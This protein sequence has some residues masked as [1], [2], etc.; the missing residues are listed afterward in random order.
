MIH[1]TRDDISHLFLQFRPPKVDYCERHMCHICPTK[2]ACNALI[3]AWYAFRSDGAAATALYD[4]CVH[5]RDYTDKICDTYSCP[6]CP[7]Y[8]WCT[9]LR[10]I[11]IEG[12]KLD[13]C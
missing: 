6:N 12:V 8:S 9:T 3:D 13:E 10:G 11:A 2:S 7:N 4:G 5:Y 1:L